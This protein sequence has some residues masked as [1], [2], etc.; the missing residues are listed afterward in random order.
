[1][2]TLNILLLEPI[3]DFHDDYKEHYTEFFHSVGYNSNISC[4]EDEK[5]LRKAIDQDIVNI[6]IFDLYYTTEDWAGLIIIQGIKRD[7][8]EIFCIG[9]SRADVSY[10]QTATKWPS[11]DMFID[12][13]GFISKDKVYISQLQN[14]FLNKFHINPNVKIDSQSNID[15]KFRSG[16]YKNEL[17]SLLSQSTFSSHKCDI[18]INGNCIMLTPLSGG[19]SGSYVYKLT[20]KNNDEKINAVAC[21]LKIS[22]KEFA[23]KEIDNYNKYVKWVLPYSWRVDLLGTGFT[24]NFGALC[25]SFVLSE[26]EEFD[27]L[28]KHIEQMDN[29]T[30]N[31]VIKKIF[32]PQKKRW[33]SAEFIHLGKNINERYLN[34]YFHNITTKNETSDKFI[35]YCQKIF[36]KI[37]FNKLHIELY[38]KKCKLPIERL[39][40]QPNGS[41]QS[42]IC[43]GDLNSNNV[44]VSK[45]NEVIFIDFQSTGVGHVFEDFITLEMS[46]RL[47]YNIENLNK[48][49]LYNWEE[50][51]QYENQLNTCCKIES[52]PAMY[53]LIYNIRKLAILNFPNERFENYYFGLAAFCCR[54]LRVTTFSKYQIGMIL[55]TIINSLSM[56]D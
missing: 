20:F 55:I 29:D 5:A 47:H 12:K 9:N 45:N 22:K 36:D 17:I 31:L 23:L 39:F 18:L 28:T 38:G 6:I 49:N 33:Y 21:V 2:N 34:R 40:G 13:G 41:Y 48:N 46:I 11:F 37:L 53:Q 19:R 51:M 3:V 25:Y 54:L 7:F 15:P 24:K 30:I 14:E 32:N 42:C 26:Y 27:S 1:M 52:L 16:K 35:D 8:P 10:R 4:V 43:H 56:L 44:I 50:I